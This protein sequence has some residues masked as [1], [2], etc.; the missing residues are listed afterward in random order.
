MNTTTSR[1]AEVRARQ[2]GFKDEDFDL[3]VRYGTP[4]GD[5]AIML[6][7]KDVANEIAERK[8]EIQK[9]ER[10]RRCKAIV[11]RETIVTVYKGKKHHRR[12]R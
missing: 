5:N 2:R 8:R 4:V 9:L 1:H 12:R 7:D 10:L 11:C 3:L 6:R